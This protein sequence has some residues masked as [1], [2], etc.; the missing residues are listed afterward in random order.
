MSMPSSTLHIPF[1]PN[2]RYRSTDAT[3]ARRPFASLAT[4]PPVLLGAFRAW[5]G[6]TVH[7]HTS[8]AQFEEGV[9]RGQWPAPGIFN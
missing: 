3:A 8:A 5:V 4:P 7:V 9:R 6:D 1:L 2:P